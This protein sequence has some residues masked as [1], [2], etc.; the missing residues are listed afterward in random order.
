MSSSLRA[1]TVRGSFLRAKTQTTDCGSVSHLPEGEHDSTNIGPGLGCSDRWVESEG[2][3][4]FSVHLYTVS[5][6]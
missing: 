6:V 2:Q 3:I 1:K 5:T 4:Y